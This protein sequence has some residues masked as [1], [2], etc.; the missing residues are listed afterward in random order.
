MLTIDEK[1]IKA[2]SWEGKDVKKITATDGKFIWQKSSLPDGYKEC[3][4]IENTNMA[5]IDTD[6]I[7]NY[8]TYTEEKV[9][10]NDFTNNYVFFTA[11][12]RGNTGQYRAFTN[13]DHLYIASGNYRADHLVNFSTNTEYIIA[14]DLNSGYVNGA[15]YESSTNA[16]GYSKTA[17]LLIA[18][19]NFD[20]AYYTSHGKIYYVKVKEGD[21]LV[22]DYVPVYNVST[23]EYGLFD[24]VNYKF[25][26]SAND[27]KFT[28]KIKEQ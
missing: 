3:E 8:K 28:G 27:N 23:S 24:K 17:H 10:I 19:D 11:N 1:K 22:R 15:K 14:L 13:G 12:D 5:Y 7:A 9:S 18:K 25:Y 26:G 16:N 4:Y 2:I 20:L 6:Y 21:T